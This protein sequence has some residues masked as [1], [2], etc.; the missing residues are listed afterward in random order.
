MA[1]QRTAAKM[2]AS[3]WLSYAAGRVASALPLLH[4]HRYR[5]LAVPVS[6]M[7]A[8][9]RGYAVR[10]MGAV[11]LSGRID[12][13]DEVIAY[14]LQQGMTPLAAGREGTLVGVTWV[15]EKSF[16]EDEVRAHY[17]LPPDAAWDTG[18]WIEEEHR[19]S[20]AFAALWAGTASW[21]RE[22]ALEW[23]I[24][25]V[26]DYNLASIRP[27]YGMGAVDLGTATFTGL[28]PLQFASRGSPYV[29]LRA[30]SEIRFETPSA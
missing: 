15:T 19:M 22:R 21:L 17:K 1:M 23:S 26:A 28:G 6:G 5:F 13:D 30:P 10:P 4:Y 24:S 8:M 29:S 27:H 16:L 14:R 25:R 12:A 2:N 11:D 20:R 7:P 9:P 3:T 18:L